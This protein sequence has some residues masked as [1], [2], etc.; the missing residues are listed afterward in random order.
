MYKPFTD[1]EFF[2]SNASGIIS[3]FAGAIWLAGNKS[4]TEIIK[5]SIPERDIP[6]I[7]VVLVVYNLENSLVLAVRSALCVRKLHGHSLRLEI[8]FSEKLIVFPL[9]GYLLL[10]S[11]I[12]YIFGFVNSPCCLV[13]GNFSK[14]IYPGSESP[15]S[16]NAWVIRSPVR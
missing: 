11:K 12:C 3:E 4:F 5:F 13:T 8:A 1:D 16:I 14:I 15:I 9:F 6:D 10:A 7:N 2:M